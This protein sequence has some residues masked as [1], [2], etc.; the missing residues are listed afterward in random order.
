MCLIVLIWDKSVL[1]FPP[2][3]ASEVGGAIL[4]VILV[5]TV[6]ATPPMSKFVCTACG[7]RGA[8]IRPDFDWDKKA[9]PVMS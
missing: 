9:S 7:K 5:E 2:L 4:E 3:A 1:L 8:D 6:D